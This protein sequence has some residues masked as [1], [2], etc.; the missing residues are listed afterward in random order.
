MEAMNMLKKYKQ[1]IMGI[2]IGIMIAAVP[3]GAAVQ[4]YTLK[5]SEWTVVVDG[6]AVVDERY[7]VLLLPPGYNYMAVGSLR[8]VC[9]KAGIEFNADVPTKEV[10]I[11]TTKEEKIVSTET[12]EPAKVEYVEPATIEVDGKKLAFVGDI[13]KLLKPKG[14]YLGNSSS[15]VANLYDSADNPVLRDIP[16]SVHKYNGASGIFIDYQYFVENIKPLIN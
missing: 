4:Q 10:R 3:V 14:Y 8:S 5:Q 6:Q 12:I 1:F 11:T 2:V 13:S 9:E 7:P 16:F 15:G